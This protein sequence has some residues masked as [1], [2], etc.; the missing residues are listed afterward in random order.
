MDFLPD[1]QIH[2]V[3]K[4]TESTN[5]SDIDIILIDK[6][7]NT[8]FSLSNGDSYTFKSDITSSESRFSVLFRAKSTNTEIG[9]I[10]TIKVSVLSQDKSI[11]IEN[12]EKVDNNLQITIFNNAGQLIKKYNMSQTLSEIKKYVIGFVCSEGTIKKFQYYT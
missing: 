5:L 9:T 3:L 10:S 4:A 2:F 12:K 8:E 1:K 11:I 6:L 7:L